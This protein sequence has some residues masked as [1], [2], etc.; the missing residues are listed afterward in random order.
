MRIISHFHGKGRDFGSYSRGK[1]S[2]DTHKGVFVRW[3]GG[4]GVPMMRN[5]HRYH[6]H[7]VLWEKGG[8]CVNA[9]SHQVNY[10]LPDT[11]TSLGLIIL[12]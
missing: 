12:Y 7:L 1:I 5:E 6:G 10:S 2:R 11:Y 3:G 4:G 8:G 9:N